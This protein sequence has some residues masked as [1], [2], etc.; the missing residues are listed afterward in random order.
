MVSAQRWEATFLLSWISGRCQQ[1]TPPHFL[2]WGTLPGS[3]R[4]GA[5]LLTSQGWRVTA[6]L[7]LHH[8][9]L[10]SHMSFAVGTAGN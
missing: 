8:F 9:I 2:H 3:P 4:E 1:G 6:V 7:N 5:P 10:S